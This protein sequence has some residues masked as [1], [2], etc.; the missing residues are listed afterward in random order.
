MLSRTII[1]FMLVLSLSFAINL[2]SPTVPNVR[3]GD[4]VDLGTIGPGQTISLKIN[5]T[6][7][8]GGI[9]G[10]GGLYDMAIAQNLPTGWRSEPSKL[11]QNPLYVTI[12]A[13]P[14]APEGNYS[15]RV[16]V[17]DENNGEKLGNVSFI[18]KIRITW[19]VMD[20]NVSPTFITV[21]PGQPARFSIDVTN[22][23]STGDAFEI[24]AIGAKR[25]EFVKSI[26]VPAK[27]SKTIYYEIAGDE[28]ETYQSTIHV[29]SL[30]SKNIADEKNVTL[31]I[32]SNL[33]GD[34]RATNN[35]VLVFPIFEAPIY[36]LAGLISNLF[37]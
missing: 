9:H 5:S 13:D 26:Y 30:A 11:Y 22:K 2:V 31:N 34:Y 4:I 23:G 3:D 1:A 6:V 15:A 12:T 10:E 28:E 32:R 21:G 8:T 25:W 27:S 18:A 24:S 16:T 29:V 14:N 35:G 19:D 20:F 36:A 7:T 17:I 33:L 37:G